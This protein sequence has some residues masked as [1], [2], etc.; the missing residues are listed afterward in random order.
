MTNTRLEDLNIKSSTPLITPEKLKAQLPVSDSAIS[1]I[2]S[3]RNAIRDILERKD[4]RLFVVIGPC[5]IHDVKA[6][7]EYAERLK[8]LSEKV[9]DTLLLVMRVYFEKPRTTVGWKG[10]INDPYLN[11]TFKIEDGLTY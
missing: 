4:H 7:K 11:D 3:G 5:S 8:A 1:S 10:L 6:A 2:E 9:G